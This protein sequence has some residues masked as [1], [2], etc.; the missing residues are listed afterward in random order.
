MQE[1]NDNDPLR[2]ILND[3]GEPSTTETSEKEIA[4]TLVNRFAD[5]NGNY[6][7]FRIFIEILKKKIYIL[8]LKY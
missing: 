7:M 1:V 6:K 2:I 4:L 3:L 5:V 8:I